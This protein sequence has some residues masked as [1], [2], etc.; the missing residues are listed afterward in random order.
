MPHPLR[1]RRREAGWI[2][3]ASC[4][5]DPLA[6]VLPA[7]L[8]ADPPPACS[9]HRGEGHWP[10]R[11]AGSLPC[12]SAPSARPRRIYYLCGRAH[13]ALLQRTGDFLLRCAAQRREPSTGP[14]C[15]GEGWTIRPAGVPDRTSGTFRPGRSPV[16]KPGRP[17]RTGRAIGSASARRGAFLF[18][19][20]LLG[21]QEKVTRPSHGD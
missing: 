4:P 13:S 3:R 20:F 21:K 9:R 6:G 17:S 19:Y 18:G 15:G 5:D 11:R 14:L 10:E 16:E 2:D 1:G 7:T 8:R 12:R